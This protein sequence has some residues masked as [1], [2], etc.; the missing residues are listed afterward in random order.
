MSQSFC[1]HCVEYI[2]PDTCAKGRDHG[3]SLRYSTK[4]P[5]PNRVKSFRHNRLYDMQNT[6]SFGLEKAEKDCASKR[7]ELVSSQL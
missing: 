3:R 4:T 6:A 2:K 5:S 1:R 7:F